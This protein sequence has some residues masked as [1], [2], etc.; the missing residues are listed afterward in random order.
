MSNPESTPT[1]IRDL[2]EELEHILETSTELETSLQDFAGRVDV[3][4]LA[5]LL[6]ELEDEERLLFLKNLDPSIAGE[7]LTETD[8]ATRISVTQEADDESLAR[9]LSEL[10]DDEAAD[11][12][13]DARREEERDSVLSLMAQAESEGLRTILQYPP[14]TAGGIM[15]IDYAWITGDMTMAQ[16]IEHIRGLGVEEAILY[17]YVIDRERHLVGCIPTHRLVLRP[18]DSVA[19]D[20]M[21]PDLIKVLPDLD[22]E[23]VAMLF[24]RSGLLAVPVVDTENR[25]IGRITIDDIIDVVREESGEDMLLMAGT[26]EDELR[27]DSPYHAAK[28]RFPWLMVSLGGE[29]LSGVVLTAFEATLQA[30]LTLAVF[31]PVI[32]ATGGN[33][34]IQ[35]STMM[36]RAISK[37][38]V[39]PFMIRRRLLREMGTA[40]ILAIACGLV[41]YGIALWWKDDSFLAMVVGLAIFIAISST[42]LFGFTTPLVFRKLGVDPAIASGPLITTLNDVLGLAIYLGL[43]TFL[44][45]YTGG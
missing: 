13:Q 15:T 39:D 42:T 41:L 21:E 33:S 22:Q 44:L 27:S 40:M 11:T 19:R 45:T 28:V 43:A 20:V 2:L 18:P 5:D 1:H 36:V 17:I 4:T 30:K 26:D 8:T 32:M 9:I 12:I 24:E 29:M 31:I 25:L 37:G 35:A 7:V 38:D 16:A 3:G 23:E 14:D 10:P 6:P 34:G